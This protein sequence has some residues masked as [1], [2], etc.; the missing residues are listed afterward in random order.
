MGMRVTTKTCGNCNRP[1]TT[2]EEMIDV[3]IPLSKRLEIND[4]FIQVTYILWRIFIVF[5]KIQVIIGMLSLCFQDGCV[6]DD[7]IVENVHCNACSG[8]FEAHNN[9]SY[10]RLPRYLVVQ[11]GR[12]DNDMN[13]IKT[14][15][16]IP[17]TMKCFCQLCAAEGDGITE[18]QRSQHEYHLYGIVVHVGERFKSGHYISYVKSSINHVL[19]CP[20]ESCCK[21]VDGNRKD[22]FFCD[23]HLITPISQASLQ[24]KIQR[25]GSMKTPYVLFYVRSD[26]L[27]KPV[28]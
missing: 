5:S 26:A 17:F 20:S 27:Q 9:I 1:S 3:N 7:S 16:P 21:I 10:L 19:V 13:K 6:T 4:N 22:W 14:A 12:F 23:D 25:E 18:Q 24:E 2:D 11:L 28:K 8:H 15:T